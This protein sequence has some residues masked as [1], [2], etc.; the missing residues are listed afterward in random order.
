M[1]STKNTNR[2][3]N[4][5]NANNRTNAKTV[6][7]DTAHNVKETIEM[8]VENGVNYGS[9]AIKMMQCVTIY[10]NNDYNTENH[11]YING[12]KFRM[13]EMMKCTMK[14]YLLNTIPQYRG[15]EEIDKSLTQSIN[16]KAGSDA[17]QYIKT[18]MKQ[19]TT[20]VRGLIKALRDSRKLNEEL[21]EIFGESRYD[22]I[23]LKG[24]FSGQ[25]AYNWKPEYKKDYSGA[26]YRL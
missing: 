11:F 19:L 26:Q 14:R 6:S 2:N 22:K 1:K 13:D 21:T 12:Y 10:E 7:N 25:L 20:L 24:D 8:A 3:N 17:P 15:V 4:V 9:S 23:F 18:R 16:F 5:K